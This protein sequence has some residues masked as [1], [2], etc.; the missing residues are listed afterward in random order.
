MLSASL[1]KSNWGELTGARSEEKE[2]E[3]ERTDDIR[4]LFLI[5]SGI[6]LFP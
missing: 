6:S 4:S 2:R 5:I 1:R 3:G